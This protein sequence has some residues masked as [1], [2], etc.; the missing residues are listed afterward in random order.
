MDEEQT[1]GPW[2]LVADDGTDFT[3]I[4]TKLA[5]EDAMDLDTEVLGSS[6]GLRAKRADLL[7]MAASAEMLEL[8]SSA[9]GGVG[10][11]ARSAGLNVSEWEKWEERARRAIAKARLGAA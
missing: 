2:F 9:V 4:A 10:H 11:L 6:E 5:I 8:L 3:A 7:V 1:P